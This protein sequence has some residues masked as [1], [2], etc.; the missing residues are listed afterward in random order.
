MTVQDL[1]FAL[2]SHAAVVAVEPESAGAGA[3]TRRRVL[4]G[5]TCTTIPKKWILQPSLAGCARCAAMG[6]RLEKV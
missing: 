4:P 1:L 6:E 3:I 5:E 2:V